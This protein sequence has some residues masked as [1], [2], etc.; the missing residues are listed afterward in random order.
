[1]C[2]P[3]RHWFF[4]RNPLDSYDDVIPE[5]VFG[6][7]LLINGQVAQ[8]EGEMYGPDDQVGLTTRLMFE[9]NIGEF[10]QASIDITNDGTT[11][12]YYHWQVSQACHAY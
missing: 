8:W 10:A 1:M 4:F 9:A 7:S 3:L 12:I 5:P 11:A 2:K 6:P